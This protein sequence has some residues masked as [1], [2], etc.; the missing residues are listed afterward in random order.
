MATLKDIAKEAGVTEMTVSN[1]LNGKIKGVRGDSAKRAEKIRKIARRLGYRPS[2]AARAMATGRFNA[3]GLL[4]SPDKPG[5]FAS[6]PM[7]QL[8]MLRLLGQR[9]LQL[10]SATV[11]EQAFKENNLP[12]MLRE[13]S[14]DGYLVDL[15]ETLNGPAY[16]YLDQGKVPL[17]SV[18]DHDPLLSVSLHEEQGGRLAVERM[19]L[20]RRSNLAY[21]GPPVK[22]NGRNTGPERRLIGLQAAAAEQNL[23]EFQI[24]SP[25]SSHAHI[26]S[27]DRLKAARCLLKQNNRPD[28]IVVASYAYAYTLLLA[29]AKEGLNVPKDVGLLCFSQTEVTASGVK[30]DTLQVSAEEWTEQAI[31]LLLDRIDGVEMPGRDESQ[32]IPYTYHRGDTLNAS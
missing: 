15:P 14:V 18:H 32:L 13:W 1:V 27:D 9:D 23:P 3:I 25:T 31:R 26:T 28:G 17:V 7:A 12:R 20:A 19:V 4:Q 30:V 10:V 8:T 5:F 16:K 22:H 11:T 21:F 2:A 24:H 6:N 29:A